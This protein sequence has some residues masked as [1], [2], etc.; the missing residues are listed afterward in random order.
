LDREQDAIKENLSRGLGL[1]GP[2]KGDPDWHGGQVQQ[3]AQL[4][5]ADGSL[6]VQLEPMEKRRSHRFARF[7]G[8]RR[9]LQ[10]RIPDDMVTKDNAAV[11]Q[12]LS[13][14]F[15]LLGRIFVPFHS[16]DGGLYMVETDQNS[17]RI[18]KDSCGDQYRLSFDAFMRWHNPLENN[19]K[20]VCCCTRLQ[21]MTSSL[22]FSL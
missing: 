14:K 22:P 4:V 7:C 13:Q 5:K 20:Q 16:K 11:K 21:N 15:I 8:S 19:F 9:I 10:L 17:G 18:P 2:W 3:L 6:K 12:F 1:M